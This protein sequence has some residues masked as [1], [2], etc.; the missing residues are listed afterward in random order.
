MAVVPPGNKQVGE[1][2]AIAVLQLAASRASF[3]AYDLTGYAV[4]RDQG[5]AWVTKP[6]NSCMVGE[7]T[8]VA[9]VKAATGK[10]MLRTYDIAGYAV[11]QYIPPTSLKAYD[12][13]GYAIV[14]DAVVYTTTPTKSVMIGK[15]SLVAVV[16]TPK[17][18]LRAYDVVGYAI[19]KYVTPRKENTVISINN[20]Q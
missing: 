5:T 7:Y 11:V 15:H 3:K 19:V 16:N 6:P 1:Y 9:V 14:K 10:R 20:S 13:A 4:V 12:L 2:S 17:R 8:A 18:V